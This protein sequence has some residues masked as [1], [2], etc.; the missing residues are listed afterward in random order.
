MKMRKIIYILL[1]TLL[2][3]CGTVAMSQTLRMNGTTNGTTVTTC[4]ATL[5]D[6]GGPNGDYQSSET[7]TITFCAVNPNSAVVAEILALNT[8]SSFDIRVI[9][10]T[11]IREPVFPREGTDISWCRL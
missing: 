3:L 4:N 1:P 8:E 9:N 7:Y 6:S 5:F 11:L 10:N 2:L